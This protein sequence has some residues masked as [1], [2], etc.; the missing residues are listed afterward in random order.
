MGFGLS[1]LKIT[2]GSKIRRLSGEF[3]FTREQEQ[4]LRDLFSAEQGKPASAALAL[5][6]ERDV[7]LLS[8]LFFSTQGGFI[9]EL[10]LRFRGR[11]FRYQFAQ[12]KLLHA[13]SLSAACSMLMDGGFFDTVV[14][15]IQSPANLPEERCDLIFLMGSMLG[16]FGGEMQSRD[17]AFA[18]EHVGGSFV[19]S[20][21]G[22]MASS[23][24]PEEIKVASAMALKKTMQN[25]AISAAFAPPLASEVLA[26]LQEYR[27]VA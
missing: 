2:L 1:A 14:G 6:K 25:P 3:A 23:R 13:C 22:L 16:E 26:R 9:D 19:R 17:A 5:G 18:S 7:Q 4:M 12:K 11:E 15:T 24:E 27:D 10:M 21:L 20:L 8:L